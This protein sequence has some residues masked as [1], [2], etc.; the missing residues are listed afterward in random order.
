VGFEVIDALATMEGVTVLTKGHKALVGSGEIAGTPVLLAKPQT[1][2][3]VPTDPYAQPC[4]GVSR[5]Y[6]TQ[7]DRIGY[8]PP[9]SRSN[10]MGGYRS[11]VLGVKSHLHPKESPSHGSRRDGSL[12]WPNNAA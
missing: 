1:Y 8:R 11:E 5:E 9:R 12:P 3:C 4:N 7:A 6:T 2:M 10:S